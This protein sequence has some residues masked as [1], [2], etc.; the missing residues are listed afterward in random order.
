MPAEKKASFPPLYKKAQ[1]GRLQVWEVRVDGRTVVTRYGE[2]GGKAQETRDEVVSGKNLGKVNET[3][4]ERQALLEA[5]SR[6][7]RQVTRKGYVEDQERALL[8]ET[9]QE[10]GIAP[11]LAQKFA[12]HAERV[13]YPVCVQ[14]KLDGERCVAVVDAGVCTLWS[15]SRKRIGSVP[16]VERAIEEV[17]RFLGV[18]EVILDGELYCPGIPFEQVMSLVRAKEP[19]PGHEKVEYHVYD[20][21]SYELA[22]DG[23]SKRCDNYRRFLE[24][25]PPCLFAV[26]T[27][28]ADDEAEVLEWFDEFK[29]AGYEG[30]M[31]RDPEAP[32]EQ[33]KRSRSL[34]KL[35][36]F[37]DDEFEVVGVEEGRGRL[38]GHVGAI[39]CRTAAGKEFRAKP[40]GEVA[41][42][43]VLFREPWQWQGK[44][45]TVRYQGMTGKEGV[46]RFPVGILPFRER[47]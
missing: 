6:W 13:T 18:N 21:A 40:R 10:G 20:C 25:P 38:A 8:G 44:W 23:F 4:A 14:P 28:T 37:D 5:K 42:L 34:L 22:T 41:T 16:H 24:T 45:M 26:E 1:T 15:R 30:A 39:V 43:R 17:A 27:R 31:V 35:K 46:P 36:S 7:D 29:R 19:K 47:P 3:T 11:M 9:D 12:D 2:L 33:G 32:Y